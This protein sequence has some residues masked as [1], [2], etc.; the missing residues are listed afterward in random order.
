MKF[1]I[2]IIKTRTNY[3][4]FF[5]KKQANARMTQMSQ[6]A[7]KKVIAKAE[8]GKGIELQVIK[9]NEAK[10]KQLQGKE[11]LPKSLYRSPTGKHF[12]GTENVIWA[13]FGLVAQYKE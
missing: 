2:R 10:N 13:S 11:M 6:M 5:R 8:N 12:Y 7:S 9:G 1:A 3:C 4:Y